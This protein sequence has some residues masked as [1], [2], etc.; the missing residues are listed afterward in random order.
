MPEKQSFPSSKSQALGIESKFEC[1]DSRFRSKPFLK[2]SQLPFT[3]KWGAVL[4]RAS[5]SEFAPI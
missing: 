4:L 2:V 3:V 5:D 1:P